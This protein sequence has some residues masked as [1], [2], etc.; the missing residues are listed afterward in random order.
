MARNVV[1]VGLAAL[2]GVGAATSET[3]GGAGPKSDR[4]LRFEE[5]LDLALEHNRHRPVAQLAVEIAEAQH[6]QALS[7]YWP[8]AVGSSAL[9]RRDQDPLFIFPEETS[10]YSLTLGDQHLETTVTVPEKR[11][12]LMDKTHFLARV[13]LTYPLYT[14]G[15]RGALTRQTTAGMEVARQAVRRTDLEVVRDVRRYY[16]GAV[17]AGRLVDIGQ[18]ALAR[19]EVTL[20]LT[21]NLYKRGSGRVKKTDFLQ[22]KVVVESVRSL[23]SRLESNRELARAALINTMGLDWDAAVDLAETEVPFDPYRADLAGLV[24][25]TYRFNPD[26]AQLQAG[27]EA[28]AARVSEARSGRLPKLALTGNLEVIANSHEGGIVGPEEQKSWLVAIGME[29]PIF[30]GRLTRNRIREARARLAQL[31]NQR[32]LLRQGLAV[33]VQALF[34]QLVRAQNQDESSGAALRAAAENRELNVRAY[35]A[36]LV[37]VQ[38]VVAAQLIAAFVDAT[39][40]KVRY[41]HL[42]AKAR[43]ECAI[44]T[45]ISQLVLEEG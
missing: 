22:H 40:Q 18:A 16:Y 23:V 24:S 41:D 27:L 44:G 1:A 10:S 25:A 14:G 7:A 17:L 11:I 36:D 5:C 39:Y 8:R 9:A 43:L 6:G 28:V 42:E 32:V 21:E 45:E 2:L 35:Q 38:D 30:D 31:E 19:L 15:L 37:E 33:Q 12:P 3:H 29:V 13:D 4:P 34:L 20:E 26:W